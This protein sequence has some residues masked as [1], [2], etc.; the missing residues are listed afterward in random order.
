MSLEEYQ[1]SYTV[2]NAGQDGTFAG[3]KTAGGNSD[4]TGYGNFYYDLYQQDF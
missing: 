1:T 2:V 3:E 4:D